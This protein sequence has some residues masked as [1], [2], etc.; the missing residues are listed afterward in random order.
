MALLPWNSPEKGGDR[1]ITMQ[2]MW[3]TQEQTDMNEKMTKVGKRWRQEQGRQV[4]EETRVTRKGGSQGL[5]QERWGRP[6]TLC[7]G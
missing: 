4:K 3:D 1:E 6:G 7:T 5:H 2:N